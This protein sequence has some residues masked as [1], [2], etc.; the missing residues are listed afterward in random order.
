MPRFLHPDHAAAAGA[1]PRASPTRAQAT[2]LKLWVVLARATEA[3][4]RHL[5]ADV[6]RHGLTLAEFGILEALYHKGPMLLG[7][8][9]RTIL[10]SSGGITYL[11]DRLEARGLVERQPCPDD[12]RAR[13]A[14][15]TREGTRLV[16]RIFPEHARRIE[17]AMGGLTQAEQKEAAELLRTLGRAAA[18]LPPPGEED[19]V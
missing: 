12:R 9:Q 17:A 2:S 4:T 8:I 6:A 16:A 18:E 3:V 19:G 15:L 10:V 7:E 11:V 13:F 5:T 1:T 14:A